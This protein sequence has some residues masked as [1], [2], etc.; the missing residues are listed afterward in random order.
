MNITRL[1]IGLSAAALAC[2]LVAGSVLRAESAPSPAAPKII[3]PLPREK[4]VP[5]KTSLLT[6]NEIDQ[7]IAERWQAERVRWASLS[8]DEQFLRRVY[9]DLT[10][11]TPTLDEVG[12]LIKRGRPNR[13]AII[14]QLLASPRY[15]DHWTTF[16]GDLL[17]EETNIRGAA[18]FAFRD[19]IRD[20]LKANKP[21]DQFVSELITAEGDTSQNPAALF[22]M[23]HDGDAEEL[24]ITL[25]QTFL[26]TQLKCAQ[27]HDHKFEPWLQ[28]D[29]E[30]MR[31]FWRGTRRQRIRE[32]TVNR[33]RG[34]TVTVPIFEVTTRR[35]GSGR[36]LTGD[37][38]E[39]GGGREALAAMM[40]DR[41]NP[42]FARVIVN[43]LWAKLMGAG[44]VEP[45]DEFSPANPPSHP[46]LL[47]WL[48]IDFIENGYDLKRTLRLICNSRTYQLETTGGV[49]AGEQGL[50]KRLFQR[51]PLKRLTA[52]QLHDSI[53]TT[54][55]LLGRDRWEPA[56]EQVYPP[57]AGS[58]LA[59]FNAHDRQTIHERSS[60]A[61]IQQALELMNGAFLNSAV[62]IG[63]DH[64]LTAWMRETKDADVLIE[65]LY[66]H[67]LT[68][69][70]TKAEEKLARQHLSSA[71]WSLDAWS[72]LHWALINTR[73]YM[74]VP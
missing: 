54:T 59:T 58:F 31:D 10:G 26:G 48:A 5:P 63:A 73:E 56:V 19:Y 7:F 18:P 4:P 50:E 14:D 8:S 35:E 44:L 68:R 22:F 43:R 11:V 28:K 27:C 21:F 64:P 34:G 38:P 70:P 37:E 17:R 9:L 46:E 30:G 52:E 32:E 71:G 6:N 23:R 72:D 62:R 49:V 66:W 36:F 1:Q 53:L 15:A 20:S 65:R 40:T 2:F 61:T 42:Y 3:A 47:D 57:R 29:F 39:L 69:A 74:F 16:W 55:G 51:M 41:R 12:A 25:T 13:A 67:T 24:T 60:E 45:V 33:P